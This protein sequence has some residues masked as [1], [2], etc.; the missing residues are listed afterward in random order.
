M[1]FK[2]FDKEGVKKLSIP[3]QQQQNKKKKEKEKKE[4]QQFPVKLTVR[5]CQNA[6]SMCFNNSQANL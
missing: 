3:P 2:Y 1:S 5:N 6:L 4:Q